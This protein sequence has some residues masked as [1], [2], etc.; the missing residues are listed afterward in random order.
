[1]A[2]PPLMHSIKLLASHPWPLLFLTLLI[3]RN[4]PL[5][6]L[7]RILN[8]NPYHTPPTPPHRLPYSRCRLL[9]RTQYP[10]HPLPLILSTRHRPF[11]LPNH[12]RA[13]LARVGLALD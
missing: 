1:M 13:G 4:T 10:Y 5:K 3:P 11:Q 6:S 7:I 9:L 2:D 12:I 8:H